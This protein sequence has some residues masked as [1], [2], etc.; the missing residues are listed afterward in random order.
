MSEM[1]MET[2]KGMLVGVSG[3]FAVLAVFFLTLRILMAKTNQK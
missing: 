3:V 2:I 1:I